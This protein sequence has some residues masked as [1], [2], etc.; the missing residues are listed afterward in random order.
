MT[1]AVFA[2]T[3][4]KNGKCWIPR[5]VCAHFTSFDDLCNPK[6]PNYHTA[7][8]EEQFK[9]EIIIIK[10]AIESVIKQQIKSLIGDL[11]KPAIT[12]HSLLMQATTD[13]HVSTNH[14][15]QNQPAFYIN[16]CILILEVIK[17]TFACGYEVFTQSFAKQ[18][19]VI[20]A[21]QFLGENVKSLRKWGIEIPG[22]LTYFE[23]KRNFS[24]H[25]NAL[26]I[27]TRNSATLWWDIK[28]I[29]SLEKQI[30]AFRSEI[31]IKFPPV[32]LETITTL[33]KEI[34]EKLSVEPIAMI[35]KDYKSCSDEKNAAKTNERLES[36]ELQ[37]WEARAKV[38]NKFFV[39]SLFVDTQLPQHISR[40]LLDS[41]LDAKKIGIDEKTGY[42]KYQIGDMT[43][44]SQL[45][46]KEASD[47]L[48]IF[49][50]ELYYY[51]HKLQHMESLL[52]LGANPNIEGVM[53]L[54]PM[55]NTSVSFPCYT[56]LHDAIVS[57]HTA[58]AKLLLQYGA[59]PGSASINAYLIHHVLD[60]MDGLDLKLLDLL[61]ESEVDLFNPFFVDF[62]IPN[63]KK[64]K[65]N[66][67]ILGHL[68]WKN[69]LSYNF[70]DP[71]AKANFKVG[72]DTTKAIDRDLSIGI[73]RI[74]YF[75]FNRYGEAA[76]IKLFQNFA[77]MIN[78]S[79]SGGREIC[80]YSYDLR[81]CINEVAEYS[82][83]RTSQIL[84]NLYIIFMGK[85]NLQL[86][87]RVLFD[88][89]EAINEF[90]SGKDSGEILRLR[91]EKPD[92][93]DWK[94]RVISFN[95]STLA[96][97]LQLENAARCLRNHEFRYHTSL[98]LNL[99]F[100]KNEAKSEAISQVTDIV[101]DYCIEGSLSK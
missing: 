89:E 28:H 20:L 32:Q 93:N 48:G 31:F 63:G 12:N 15:M 4:D 99:F 50:L 87:K 71:A 57:G 43:A 17:N 73:G 38:N 72:N 14:L 3:Q 18:A 64:Y 58:E 83:T 44:V 66:T 46:K 29:L 47:M 81:Y 100:S 85:N 35:S 34:E 53:K 21:R 26:H 76:L 11:I 51:H 45:K 6:S 92:V 86:H 90:L 23:P 78:E 54:R 79:K 5:V 30:L 19:L 1:R 88:N 84:A 62:Y 49:P 67:S 42:A 24:A 2:E 36:I 16:N 74:I 59:M 101:A 7:K 13:I 75:I 52:K 68:L 69:Y 10:A 39:M 22:F 97:T 70:S 37:Y 91:Q 27:L 98:S 55:I 8:L 33:K 25:A 96:T 95:A 61:L 80:T 60:M 82:A 77:V 65:V 94:F 41:A 9:S 56:L 40:Y